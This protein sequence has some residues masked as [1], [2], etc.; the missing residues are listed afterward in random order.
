MCPRQACSAYTGLGQGPEPTVKDTQRRPRPDARRWL[1]R[2]LEALLQLRHID[3]HLPP[4]LTADEERHEEPTDTVSLEVEG[5][6]QVRAPIGARFD[7]DVDSGPDGTIHATDA[8]L[9]RRIKA[10]ELRGNRPIGEADTPRRE[11]VV[12]DFGHAGAFHPTTD[13]ALLPLREATRVGGVGEHL[14][15]RAVDLDAGSDRWH[16]A[17]PGDEVRI[18]SQVERPSGVTI[19]T[20]AKRLPAWSVAI[21]VAVFELQARPLRRLGD[22][23]DFDLAGVTLVCLEL[24]L[25]ADIP[26]EDDPIGWFIGQ[27]ASLSALAPVGGAV[28]DVATNPRLEPS[29]GDLGPEKVVLRRFEVTEPLNKR[30]KGI[31]DR[32]VDDDLTTDDGIIGHVHGFSSGSCSTSSW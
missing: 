4:S 25:R 28:I 32:R 22:K 12:T 3:R 18:A 19:D 21:E 11:T 9:V 27:D 6:H 31:L 30:S 5:D 29:L 15:G 17:I 7:R 24:P 13:D 23:P 26:A 20:L 2:A 16:L 10:D 8:P 1:L 14:L